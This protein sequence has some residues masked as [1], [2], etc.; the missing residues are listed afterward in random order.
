MSVSRLADAVANWSARDGD[1]PAVIAPDGAFSWTELSSTT[2]MLTAA[3][4]SAQVGPRTPVA[5]A[6]GLSRFSLAAL[7]AVWSLGA[8]A[9]LVDERHPP[10]RLRHVLADSGARFVL[11]DS[12]PREAGV[13]A[14]PV[15][16]PAAALAL[17]AAGPLDNALIAQNPVGPA[18]SDCAYIIY[19]SGTTGHP[20]G[21][22]ISYGNLT[23]FLGALATLRLRPGGIGINA[24]SPA[25]DGWLWCALLYLLHGQGMAIVD[26][27]LRDG[28]E[29]LSALIA[30]YDPRTICLTPTLLSALEHIPPADVVVVAGEACPPPL[31]ARLADIPRVLNVYG[32]TE[33]T[34]AA[35]WADTARG[36][37]PVTIGRALPGYRT[38]VLDDAGRP[39]Q[40]GSAGELYIGGPAVGRGYRNLPQL[41]S[42]RFLPDTSAGGDSRM[43]RTG[44]LVRTRPDGQLEFLG[45]TDKQV[46]VRGFRVELA[47]L[48]RAAL[49]VPQVQAAAAFAFP[50]GD[51]LGLAVTLAAR[52]DR[53]Q[54]AALVRQR[55]ADMLPGYMVPAAVDVMTALP[56]LPTGK[57]DREALASAPRPSRSAG[58][59]PG[60]TREGQ[61][62]QVWSDVLGHPVD[63]VHANFF[64]IG[65]HSLLAARAVGSLRRATGLPVSVRHLLEQPTAAGLAAELDNLAADAGRAEETR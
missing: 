44:D 50:A 20:K 56:T 35:T 27:T 22:E 1:N 36:D 59:P 23:A 26:A 10:A 48:E 65:G 2:R 17:D 38:Y 19:T 24:V 52:A 12:W 46:K 63:D 13:S 18:S 14:V 62:C 25:F 39:V 43:Y 61:V 33:T 31:A 53:Q 21:V 28:A 34:I 64:E 15:I 45:R 49:S 58:T 7:L 54:C 11:G 5:L 60:T 9:V 8:T 3:L 30:K 32:P 57:V 4:A 37:D 16:R 47:E 29:D 40:A 51:S 42:E 6:T 55:C 41:T